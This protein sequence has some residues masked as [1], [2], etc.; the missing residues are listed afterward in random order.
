[1]PSEVVLVS[2]ASAGKLL[3][4]E[5]HR[6]IGYERQAGRSMMDRRPQLWGPYYSVTAAVMRAELKRRGIDTFPPAQGLWT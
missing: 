1:M 4:R 6:A 5:L 2:R 3:D